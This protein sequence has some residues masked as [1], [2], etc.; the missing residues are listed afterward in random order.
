M[1]RGRSPL[2]GSNGLFHQEKKEQLLLGRVLTGLLRGLSAIGGLLR[3][4]R[5]TIR[6]SRH[7]MAP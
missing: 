7:F 4:D 5:F 6:L 1:K 3:I 2:F